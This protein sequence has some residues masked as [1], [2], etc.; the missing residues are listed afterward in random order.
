M[1]RMAPLTDIRIL[2]PDDEGLL[3]AVE[4]GVFDG[5]LQPELVHAFLTDP[6][7]HLAVALKDD[8]VIG[9]A[10]AFHYIHPDKSAELFINEVG[11]AETARGRG[12]GGRLVEALLLLAKTLRCR[13]AWV[14]ADP[15]NEGAA[16]LYEGRGGR[17]SQA[18]LYSWKLDEPP[19]D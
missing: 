5:P 14:L 16:G 11:V 15:D 3:G 19:A 6:R 4:D 8:R 9:M 17:G 13:E 2:G 7:H 18:V 10:S 1:R 12:V